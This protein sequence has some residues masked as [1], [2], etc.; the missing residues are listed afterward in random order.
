MAELVF[1]RIRANSGLSGSCGGR[2]I[3]PRARG[4]HGSLFRGGRLPGRRGLRRKVTG[5]FLN[6]LYF[7]GHEFTFCYNFHWRTR[8]VRQLPIFRKLLEIR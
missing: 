5:R 7:F 6:V 3:S 4:L 2:I 8:L 1:G